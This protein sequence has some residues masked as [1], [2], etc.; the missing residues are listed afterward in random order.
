MKI[1]TILISIAIL[2]LP[3]GSAKAKP[4]ETAQ[5]SYDYLYK[6]FYTLRMDKSR[7]LDIAKTEA[8]IAILSRDIALGKFNRGRYVRALALKGINFDR[9]QSGKAID[10]AQSEL[11]LADFEFLTTVANS[12]FKRE[13]QLDAGHVAEEPKGSKNQRGQ[14]F[15]S[16]KLF[17]FVKMGPIW[18][19][20]NVK[21]MKL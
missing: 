21:L 3:L 11:A 16:L 6:M 7:V 10:I 14:V 19:S 2:M 1:L 4:F 12:K 13:L 8:G 18:L 9:K 20:I 17:E 5:Q 15:C